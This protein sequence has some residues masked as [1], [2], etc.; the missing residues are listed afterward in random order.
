MKTKLILLL[1]SI[2]VAFSSCKKDDSVTDTRDKY[3]GKWI[4]TQ[5]VKF[6]DSGSTDSFPVTYQI[7]KGT[8]NNQIKFT[9]SDD[10]SIILTAY[11]DNTT[12]VYD[13]YTQ[14]DNSSGT[15][16]YME[17]TGTGSISGNTITDSGN[18]LLQMDGY[19]YYGTWTQKLTKAAK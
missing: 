14:T 3:V 1:I 11:V 15:L 13:K 4:G 16:I 5:T 18:L 6:T 19:N 12:H 7:T 9:D 2:T 10:A 17:Q 8:V